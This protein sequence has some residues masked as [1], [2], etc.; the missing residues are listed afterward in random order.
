MSF[1]QGRLPR[2]HSRFAPTLENYLRSHPLT[3]ATGLEKVADSD[4][5]DRATKV[6]E[7][8]VY[9][10]D[11]IGDCTIA[12][13]AHSF[14]AMGVFAGKPFS[15]FPEDEIVW[16]YSAVSGYDPD[17]GANDNGAQMQDVLA[18]MRS[19][20]MADTTGKVHKVIAYAALGRP[21]D[22]LLLSE[23]LKTFGTVYVGFQC[24]Q[25][26]EEQFQNG[27]WTYQPG[28]PILGGHAISLH[29]RQPY[30]SRVGVFGF[31]TWGAL[32]PVTI[33]FLAHYVE[34]AWVFVTQD[35]IEANGSS[36]DGI[37]LAQLEAD[38]RLVG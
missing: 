27:P 20:G 13:M 17:T 3:K 21:S 6:S 37:S 1:K 7:W 24:P 14:A 10:N 35:W 16:A 19:E 11:R 8:P 22:P 34:E 32:Q 15:L 23:C 31:S 18:Y 38:M 12:A 36:M 29:R 5:V 25:S 4:D 33:P 28:S 9:G 2:D 30:G 26:A